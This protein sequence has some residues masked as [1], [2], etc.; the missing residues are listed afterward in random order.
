MLHADTSRAM[1]LPDQDS[2]SFIFTHLG[3]HG[4]AR[5]PPSPPDTRKTGTWTGFPGRLIAVAEFRRAAGERWALEDAGTRLGQTTSGVQSS[6]GH[7]VSGTAPGSASGSWASVMRA[8][9]VYLL[10]TCPSPDKLSSSRRPLPISIAARPGSSSILGRFG[11]RRRCL[12]L[13]RSWPARLARCAHTTV[14]P[15]HWPL[16][17]LST[18]Y[19]G[20]EVV[21]RM[22]PELTARLGL[23]RTARVPGAS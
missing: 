10:Y 11:H 4:L 16:W 17:P 21:A 3:Q 1:A 15:C 23:T 5:R 20:C 6:G 9:V 19:Q 13:S 18:C 8:G 22:R 2:P 12:L 14:R 7:C